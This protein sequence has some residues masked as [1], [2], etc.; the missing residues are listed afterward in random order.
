[1]SHFESVQRSCT[2][3]KCGFP[4]KLIGANPVSP[5]AVALY[6]FT[7]LFL[8]PFSGLIATPALGGM[9]LEISP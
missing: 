2:L 6:G 9:L 1:M 7:G 3:S 5:F 8:Y 4:L